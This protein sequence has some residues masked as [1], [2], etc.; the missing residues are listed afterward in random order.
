M[1]RRILY[2]YACGDHYHLTSQKPGTHRVN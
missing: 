2:P 1:D